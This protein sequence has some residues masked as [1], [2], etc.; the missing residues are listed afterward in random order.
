MGA[1]PPTPG[2]PTLRPACPAPARRP[3]GDPSSSRRQPLTGPQSPAACTTPTT[4]PPHFNNAG[5]LPANHAVSGWS[6][7]ELHGTRL[8]QLRFDDSP[9]QIGAPACQRARPYC[10]ST[11]AGSATTPRRQ[12]RNRGRRFRATQRSAAGAIRAAQGLQS[13]ATRKPEPR[14]RA[15]SMGARRP[16]D[17]ARSPSPGSSP[18]VDT[19]Q[20]GT[21]D[22]QPAARPTDDIKR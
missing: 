16:A 10:S 4:A 11:R 5:S 13:P 7:R 22:L 14:A 2:W 6:T 19:H 15:R 20:A 8:Q 12:S 9:G 3:G 18:S 1:P 21:A 17:T